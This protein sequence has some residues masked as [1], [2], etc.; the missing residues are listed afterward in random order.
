MDLATL[1]LDYS[2]SFTDIP[3]TLVGASSV[4]IVNQNVAG[5][6]RTLTD[7]EKQTQQ[8]IMDR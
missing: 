5:R 4:D 7:T 6:S 2:F 3:M 1:A 8:E